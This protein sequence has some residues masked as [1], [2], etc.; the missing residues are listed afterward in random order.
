MVREVLRKRVVYDKV[1]LWSACEW[2][3]FTEIKI[4]STRRPEMSQDDLSLRICDLRVRRNIVG[5]PV[6]ALSAN[7]DAWITRLYLPRDD[8]L[9]ADRPYCAGIR[10]SDG[11]IEHVPRNERNSLD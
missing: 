9:C 1:N 5:F 10:A 8:L 6:A 7:K 3:A 2:D 4:Q 11:W